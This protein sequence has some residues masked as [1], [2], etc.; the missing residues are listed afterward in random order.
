MKMTRSKKDGARISFKNSVILCRHLR[1]KKLNKSIKLLE[2]L[3]DESRSLKGKYLTNTSKEFLQVLKNAEANAKQ[4]GFNLDKT[5][6][7]KIDA[8]EGFTFPRNRSKAKLRGTLAKTTNI[9]VE[10]EER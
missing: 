10:V 3:V 8:G 7:R 4:K 2:D 1:G 5:F 6:V 9:I